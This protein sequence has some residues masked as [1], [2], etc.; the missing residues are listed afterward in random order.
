MRI[1]STITAPLLVL[2]V[3]VLL[4]LSRLLDLN[5]LQ[6][7]DNVYL[8]MI[9]LQLLILVLPAFFYCKLKGEG[10]AGKLRLKLFAP[11]KWLTVFYAFGVLVC[12]SALINL[13]MHYL[14]GVQS[15]VDYSAIPSGSA[16]LLSILYVAVTFAVVPAFAE[17]FLFRG[18]FLAEY[19]PNGSITAALVSALLFAMVHFN[20]RGALV[21]FFGGL[22]FAF[23]TY[24]TDSLL[25]S[26]LLHM[27]YNLFGIFLEGYVWSLIMKPNSLVFFLFT[28]T[29]LFFV[30]LLLALHDAERLYY[31][32][33]VRGDPS[34]PEEKRAYY[35]TR[36]LSDGLFSP[37]V[38]ACIL[39]F[40]IVVVVQA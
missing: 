40:L 35:G 34:P 21:Y 20:A 29:T 7:G 12:G 39:F 16:N 36:A 26:M 13:G 33:G 4:I 17:E 25:C 23:V 8:T 30:F 11:R 38:L 31:I 14:F 2:L 15:T 37:G 19:A 9:V 32:R 27:L 28:V 3:Y 18:V 22:V 5:I 6:S 1:K 24:V 10:F